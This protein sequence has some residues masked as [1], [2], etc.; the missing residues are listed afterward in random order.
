MSLDA[1][2]RE[3]GTLA[4][5]LSVSSLLAWDMRTMMP[6]GGV[7]TRYLKGKYQALYGLV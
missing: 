3:I 1:F 6:S 4:D 7:E 2:H 5:L